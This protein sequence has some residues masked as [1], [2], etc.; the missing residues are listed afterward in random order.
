ME[1]NSSSG[2]ESKLDKRATDTANA[3]IE[4]LVH[5][6]ELKIKWRQELESNP[7]VVHYFQTFKGNALEDFLG[8]YLNH[9][10]LYYTYGEM[11]QKMSDQR[12]DQWIDKAHEQLK[13]ILQKQLFDKQ[14]L[15]RAEQITLEGVEITADFGLWSDDIFNCPFLD[16]ITWTDIEMYQAFLASDGLDRFTIEYSTNDW[17][18]YKAFKNSYDSNDSTDSLEMPEWYDF[19]NN[20]TG[21]SSL[22]LMQD[23]RGAKE[24]FY[25]DLYFKDLKPRRDAEIAERE[26]NSDKRPF[27]YGGSEEHLAYFINTFEDR[28]C[29]K[30]YKYCHEMTHNHDPFD[31]HE[32]IDSV[33]EA[34]EP[35][36]VSS[37]SNLLEA[38]EIA[39]NSYCLHKIAAH[40]PLAFEHY[41]F[42]Q[43][44][45][46][47]TESKKINYYLDIKMI[48]SDQ[49]LKGRELNGDEPDFNF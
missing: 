24:N 6:K 36:P 48:I 7:A 1:K 2:E 46:I 21:N 33:I 31:F 23:I 45:E 47:S 34:E 37:H 15:W 39:Y 26:K 44:M 4:K 30:K 38:V 22:F 49:I 13:N 41:L 20:K 29:Q 5:E 25:I 11:Y 3:G 40:L 43:K 8:T 18:D 27:L 19:H 32:L 14:C 9:K 10:Y 35:I 42:T 16:P 17:Q 12:R 28:D